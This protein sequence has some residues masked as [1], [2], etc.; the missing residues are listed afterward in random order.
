M[1]GKWYPDFAPIVSNYLPMLQDHKFD[2]YLCGH[3]HVI[4]YA[5]YPYDQVPDPH[6]ISNNDM[7]DSSLNDYKCAKN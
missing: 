5:S 3:E 1:W 6:M 4:T 2:L 7:Q